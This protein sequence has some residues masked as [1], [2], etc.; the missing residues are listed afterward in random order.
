ML[1]VAPGLTTKSKE[2]RDTLKSE[3]VRLRLGGRWRDLALVAAVSPL[4]DE[5]NC[6]HV[7]ES[8]S[9]QVTALNTVLASSLPL[10]GG[11]PQPG[12]QQNSDTIKYLSD[13]ISARYQLWLSS[14]TLDSFDS[15]LQFLT[16]HM[17][18]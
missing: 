15:I 6:L 18:Q 13:S 1:L 10:L 14:T 7:L 5:C 17:C 11:K 3:P 12:G 9:A 8:L 4:S 16:E 2:I